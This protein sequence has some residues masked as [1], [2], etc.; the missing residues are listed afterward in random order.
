MIINTE[1]DKVYTWICVKRLSL[2]IEKTK[3]II[4]HNKGKITDDNLLQVK[5]LR[6]PIERVKTFNFL[7]VTLD[8]NLTW[9]NHIDIICSKVP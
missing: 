9:T 8:Q 7:G 4:F 2:N 3:F 5:L 6:L 1:L